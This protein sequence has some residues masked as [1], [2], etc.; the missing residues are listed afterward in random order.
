VVL[1]SVPDFHYNIVWM[2]SDW[3]HL[4]AQLQDAPDILFG[5][6]EGRRSDVTDDFID[7]AGGWIYDKR[8][9]EGWGPRSPE[10]LAKIAK[11]LSEA[12]HEWD[13]EQQ[14]EV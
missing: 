1:P 8:P 4:A 6:Q 13:R 10:S 14:E 2:F 11:A 9:A 7:A 3:A 12:W 5:A